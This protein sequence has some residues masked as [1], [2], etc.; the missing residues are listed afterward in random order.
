MPFMKSGCTGCVRTEGERHGGGWFV[1]NGRV[2][3]AL[4]IPAL[5]TA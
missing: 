3:I 4:A 5:A 1:D 2:A